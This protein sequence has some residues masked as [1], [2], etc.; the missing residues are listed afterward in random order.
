MVGLPLAIQGEILTLIKLV[1]KAIPVYGHS[2]AY[3]LMG[4]VEKKF[5][6]K[7]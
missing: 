2:L 3:I 7:L 1:L 5:K 4:I 6:E